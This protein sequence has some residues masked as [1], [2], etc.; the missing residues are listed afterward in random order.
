[1]EWRILVVDDDPKVA[2]RI[3]RYAAKGKLLPEGSS[4]TC[5]H[6]HCFSDALSRITHSQY[7]F[8]VLDVRGGE[9]E[10]EERCGEEVFESI[11]ART[12]VPVV[13]YTAAPRLV[14]G[15]ET[16]F[17]RVVEKTDGLPYLAK[18]MHAIYSTGLPEL[19]RH[20]EETQREYLWDFVSE[21]WSSLGTADADG[22]LAYLLAR[23]IAQRLCLH[24]VRAFLS[25]KGICG[26]DAEDSSK[27]H[28]AEMYVYPPIGPVKN[29]FLGGDIVTRKIDGC[30]EHLVVVTPSCD[31]EQG[32]TDTVLLA[33]CTPIEETK[34][35][36]SLANARKDG[37]SLKK[38]SK[39]VEA[40]I[41]N[42]RSSGQRDRHHFL[43][44]F[45]RIPHLV[46]DFGDLVQ[47]PK[48]DAQKELERIATLDAPFAEALL[49]RFSRHYGRIGTPDLYVE[50]IVAQITA[51]PETSHEAA[52]SESVTE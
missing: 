18:E 17:V 8:V 24:S 47:L 11:K 50:Q 43:P 5:D 6:E 13:F 23:R 14:Q 25:A 41:G 2:E 26:P 3:T 16:A 4:V 28:A 20:I 15:Y 46:V 44:R 1:M 27:S 7:D 30:P 34:E 39:A 49:I 19:R 40:L 10:D 37:K 31:L 51:T 22:C 52:S 12:F 33:R 9:G 35:Y 36:V 29:G 48:A 38:P 32:K 42:N 21:H 45:L